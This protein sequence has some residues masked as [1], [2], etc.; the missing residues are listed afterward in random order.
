MRVVPTIPERLI[1]TLG[2]GCPACLFN[3]DTCE[4]DDHCPK[5]RD[6]IASMAYYLFICETREIGPAPL[7]KVDENAPRAIDDPLC[8]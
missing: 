3:N 7:P 5:C 6:Q 2:N 1:E 4:L 8:S